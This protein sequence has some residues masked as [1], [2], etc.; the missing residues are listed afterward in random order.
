MGKRIHKPSPNPNGRPSVRTPET[1]ERICE[2]VALGVPYSHAVKLAGIGYSTFCEWRNEDPEFEQKL[3]AALS[4]SVEARLK[5]IRDNA[6]GDWRC[7]AWFLEHVLPEHF[8]KSR[9]QVEAIG[10]F[11]HAFVIPQETLNQ[12]AEARAKHD[13]ERNGTPLALPPPRPATR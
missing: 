12:I 10:E 9:I 1:A 6:A 2:A 8:A 11:N 4:E 3:D 13:G 7:A 5:I